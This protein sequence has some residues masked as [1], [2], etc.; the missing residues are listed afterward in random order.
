VLLSLATAGELIKIGN[1]PSAIGFAG[2]FEHRRES[3]ADIRDPLTSQGD[4]TGTKAADTQG[5]YSVN[6]AFL[7]LNVPVLSRFGSFAAPGTLLELSAAG[8]FVSYSTFGGNFTYK[9]GARISP[10]QDFT[11]RGTF[12]TAFRAPAVSELYLGAVD[13]FPSVTDPCANRTQGTPLDAAC[14]AQGVP[15]DLADDR[16]Q[17]LT[18]NGG[19]AE[20]DP[21]TARSFTIGAVLEPRWVKD[22]ALTVDYY[23]I[24]VT[25]SIQE[26][27]AAVILAS[28]YPA[29]GGA[30][31]YCDRIHR[32]EEGLI[33][34]IDDP[35]SNVGG[36]Q[37][38][39][40]DLQVDYSPQTPVGA[41]GLT[42]NLNYLGFFDRTLADGR[43]INAKG[44]YDLELVLPSWKGNFTVSYGHSGWNGTMTV[45]WVD[46]FREC[47]DN[48][49]QQTDPT[50]PP[51]RTR[52]VDAY[53]AADLNLGYQ[54]SHSG[55]STSNF[56]FGVNNLFDATPPYIVNGF[57]AASDNTA[58]DYMGRYFYV[59]MSH[60]LK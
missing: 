43:V 13:D 30:P 49:C 56:S 40:V 39:G 23:N 26:V 27:T 58:Y 22:L 36:D 42:V 6:E 37:I 57:T 29:Q 2:G 18:R 45:R 32:N 24:K 46:S 38:S 53:A 10:L 4:T 35:L 17:I 33:R 60:E 52:D 20:L 9:A 3:G 28:C 34:S 1:A 48:A 54:L 25:N 16:G 19:N 7:E 5:S 41:I 14:D 50:A 59:R 11:L 21:E 12:A 51:P 47:E 55:G 31:A 8:R 15:D 44:T